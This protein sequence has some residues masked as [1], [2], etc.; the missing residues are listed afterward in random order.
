MNPLWSPTVRNLQ[1]PELLHSK[2]L[3]GGRFRRLPK[4]PRSEAQKILRVYYSTLGLDFRSS[5]CSL[6]QSG[7][8]SSIA[9]LLFGL[10]DA[11]GSL[12]DKADSTVG[13]NLRGFWLG[14]R[15]G[16]GVL[17]VLDSAYRVF[18]GPLISVTQ[19]EFEA[20]L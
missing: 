8:R 12:R 13:L 19:I 16:F 15:D 1:A 3:T 2:P 6:T 9:S 14:F 18:K 17:R 10:H 11:K 7:S 4:L 5:F 20:R